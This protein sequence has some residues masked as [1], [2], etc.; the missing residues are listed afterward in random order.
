MIFV[1][2]LKFLYFTQFSVSVYT[3]FCFC[4][5]TLG[6]KRAWVWHSVSVEKYASFFFFVILVMTIIQACILNII[7]FHEKLDVT[8]KSFS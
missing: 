4:P 6:P 5:K 2:I 3:G 7:H 1:T 8:Q